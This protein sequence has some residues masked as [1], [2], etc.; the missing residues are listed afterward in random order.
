M[1]SLWSHIKRKS[2]TGFFIVLPLVV[3]ILLITYV[4]DKVDKYITPYVVKLFKL[5]KIELAPN[6]LTNIALG[7][8]GLFFTFFIIYVIGLLGSN[9]IGKRFVYGFD[10]L[11]LRLPLVKGIYGGARQLI[12]SISLPKEGAF[13]RVVL[14]QYP[15]EGIYT[16]GFATSDVADEIKGKTDKDLVNIFIPTSPVPA[17]GMLVLVPRKD[18]LFL[19]ISIEEAFTLIV[20]GGIVQA[21]KK[22]S[23]ELPT[24]AALIEKKKT[25]KKHFS[26]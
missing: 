5:L 18:V 11:M 7:L 19:D 3:T 15:R 26:V 20:S 22:K 8:I 13:E 17:S 10:N 6:Y 2:I 4:F 14:I 12:Q 21:N 9:I 24:K 25:H 23:L 1:M 16:I